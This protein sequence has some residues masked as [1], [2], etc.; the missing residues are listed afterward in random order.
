[1]ED[2]AMILK[3]ASVVVNGTDLSAYVKE[4]NLPQGCKM[5]DDTV[6]GDDTEASAAG[7]LTWSISVTFKQAYGAGLVDA[8]L[9]A[10]LGAAAFSVVVKPDSGAVAAGNPSW[11]GNA[12]LSSYAP[13]GGRVGVNQTTQ[14]VFN[15]AGTL[16]R[17]IGA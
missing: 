7:L 17:G 8:T 9:S 13:V 16:T 5:E 15:S 6:M 4:V 12:V 14:A 2:S 1:M 11:T 10:L 3:N